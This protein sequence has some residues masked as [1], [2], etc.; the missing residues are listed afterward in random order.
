MM[1]S[2]TFIALLA[3]LSSFFFLLFRN[4]ARRL[5]PGPKPWPLLGN[6]TDLRPKELWLLATDWA[7]R[8]GLSWFCSFMLELVRFF[9]RR[10]RILAPLRP[11]SYLF[12]LS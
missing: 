4:L 12:K 8:Y 11:G 7:N 1:A 6:I 2:K 5:P 9:S 10:R 3:L